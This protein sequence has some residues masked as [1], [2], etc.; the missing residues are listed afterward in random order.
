MSR[1]VMFGLILAIPFM[2]FV[3][4][5][6]L[7]LV[8]QS[9]YVHEILV[10]ANFSTSVL[11][12][13]R[14]DEVRWTNK[15]MMPISIVFPPSV[16]PKLSCRNNFEGF[17]TGGIETTLKHNESASLCFNSSTFSYVVRMHSVLQTQTTNIAGSVAVLE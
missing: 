1:A 13:N 8:T 2:N 12:V 16:H 10:G 5:Q 7:P 6:Q 3:S 17:Y 11:S 15:Q 14:D 9:G 4:C